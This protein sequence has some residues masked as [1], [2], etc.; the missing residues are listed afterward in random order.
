M[1]I[2]GLKEKR[3]DI[4]NQ[5]RSIL[6]SAKA[7]ERALSDEEASKF[8]A[9]DKEVKSI[10]STIEREEKMNSLEEKEVKPETI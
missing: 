1:N 5:M 4:K 2:K 9:L 10:D 3:E 6:D 8:D 7:E